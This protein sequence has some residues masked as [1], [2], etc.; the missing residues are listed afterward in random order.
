MVA[1]F[2]VVVLG[3]IY[4]LY[5]TSLSELAPQED[6]GVLI[7][8]SFNAPTATLLQR[9]GYGHQVH[10]VFRAH[11]ETGHIFQLNTPTQVISGMVLKP[12]D[13]RVKTSNQLQPQVP[14][15]PL[16][17]SAEAAPVQVAKSS[18][19]CASQCA[20]NRRCGPRSSDVG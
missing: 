9:E 12:W 7:A 17:L 5:S 3:G 8:A 15:Q 2:A 1:V 18:A 4:F 16:P 19:R 6:Q 14:S 11:P 13:E 10:D 20:S